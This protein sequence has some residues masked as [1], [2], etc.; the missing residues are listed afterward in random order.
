[1]KRRRKKM[2]G[3]YFLALD[4]SPR[5]KDAVQAV[6]APLKGQFPGARWVSRDNYHI[7]LVFL[8]EREKDFL[9]KFAR[10]AESLAEGQPPFSL[11]LQGW[12]FFPNPRRARVMYMGTGQGAEAVS[13]LAGA[14]RAWA[15]EEEKCFHPHLTVARFRQ[16][17]ALV[18]PED[19]LPIVLEVRELT[20]FSSTLTPAGP[21]YRVVDKF[22]LSGIA[23]G[24]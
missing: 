23:R 12:G 22:S 16:P 1:M 13:F 4:L 17:P 18:T 11:S 2:A 7:T 15:G 10:E 20:L 21:I 6:V 24:E 3:R 8:G 9:D 14:L 5:A 19:Y